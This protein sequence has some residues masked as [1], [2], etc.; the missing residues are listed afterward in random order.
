MKIKN[1]TDWPDYF[2]RRLVTWCCKELGL[3]ARYLK[4]ADFGK[5][6]RGPYNGCAWL[7]SRR[8][9]VVI[10]PPNEF[11][12]KGRPYPGRTSEVFRDPDYADQL[13]ALIGVTAHEIQHHVAY[14]QRRVSRYGERA[15]T[16]AEHKIIECFR[17]QRDALVATWSMEPKRLDPKKTRQEK[18]EAHAR[19]MLERWERKLKL[20]KTKAGLYR[21]KVRYY[22]RV[23][24]NRGRR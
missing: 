10:G 17:P 20:A 13:E 1:N 7:G 16:H 11:P 15:T 2:L 24:A 5:R 21:S 18:N 4:R 8:M 19:K 6:T 3:P 22:D 9:R 14:S 23:A 12:T